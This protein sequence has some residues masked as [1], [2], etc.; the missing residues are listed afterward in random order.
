MS[1]REGGERESAQ[2]RESAREIERDDERERQERKS[3]SLSL[4]ISLPCASVF[5]LVLCILHLLYLYLRCV[6]VVY[7]VCVQY[8]YH[9]AL[10][11][12][13]TGLVYECG[14]VHVN[15][16]L[17]YEHTHGIKTHTITIPSDTYHLSIH[18]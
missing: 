4:S 9:L 1:E 2:G 14:D 13:L 11:Q 17:A 15:N 6:F 10:T 5:K 8:L 12:V 3:S 7:Y 16:D 18:V